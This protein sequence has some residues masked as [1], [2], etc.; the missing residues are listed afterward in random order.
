VAD[1]LSNIV[2]ERY[3]EVEYIEPTAGNGAFMNI[4]PGIKGYDLIPE[5]DNIKQCDVFKNIFTPTQVIVGNPP[6]GINANLAVAIFNHIA[7]FNVKAI[8]F[9]LPKTFKKVGMHNKLNK[10]YHLV[11]EQDLINNAFLLK[12]QDKHVPC[13]FQIWEFKKKLR[14]SIEVEECKW[15]EFTSKK[16][17]DIAVRRA[18]SK[19]GQLLNGL[20]H[21]EVSTYFLKIKHPFV[22]KALQLIN[23][24]VV[25]YTAG[26]RSIS[27]PELCTELNR[28]MEILI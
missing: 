15:V 22:I 5:A 12:G 11:F 2:L 21:S 3:G 27:K 24:D 10:K 8:C 25:E 6:F 26:V 16:N 20:Q 14:N 18:G 9:I 28:V 4:L 13:V 17:A 7:S 19:A 1:Y 23:L